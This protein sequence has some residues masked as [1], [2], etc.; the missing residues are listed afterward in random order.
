MYNVIH[1]PLTNAKGG[2]ELIIQKAIKEVVD[3]FKAGKTVAFH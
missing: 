1:V 3:A 2:Q